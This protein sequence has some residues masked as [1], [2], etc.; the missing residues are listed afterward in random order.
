MQHNLVRNHDFK[1]WLHT[2]LLV[3]SMSGLLAL[4]GYFLGGRTGIIWAIVLGGVL[5]LIGQGASPQM[6]LRMY[7]ARPIQAQ[8]APQ[9]YQVIEEL[10][11]RAD[12]PTIP[13]LH[14]VPSPI[15]NAFAVGTRTNAAIGITDGILRNLNLREL[16]GVLAHEMSHIRN[17]D[18]RVMA[19]ADTISRITGIFSNFG[20]VLLVLNLPLI[21]FGQISISW[22]AL[23]LMIVAPMLSGL[24]QLALSRTR[25]FDADLDAVQLTHDP[26]GLASALQKLERYQTNIWQQV[27]MPGYRVPDPSILRTHPHTED[28][29]KRLLALDPQ[30]ELQL[31]APQSPMVMPKQIVVVPTRPVWRG[32]MGLWY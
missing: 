18:M 17:N 31:S 23:L 30:A 29:V 20:K 6:V 27:L 12:L 13:Q 9:L 7:K 25:E 16:T 11:R 24:L 22:W 28:R 19:F 10:S 14:Y 2:L 32:V 1:N 8:E 5:L 26:V 15:M 3:I 4:L 21:L